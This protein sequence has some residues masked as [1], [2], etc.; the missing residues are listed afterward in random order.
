MTSYYSTL[1]NK[2]K[3]GGGG[4]GGGG[5]EITSYYSILGR[6]KK[7]TKITSYYS[8]LENGATEITSYYSILGGVG[9]RQQKW[10]P[11]TPP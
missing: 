2:I 5:A 3:K 7:V 8:T 10:L 4:G 6:G 1:K 11:I 9:G